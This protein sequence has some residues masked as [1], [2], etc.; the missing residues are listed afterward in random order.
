[1]ELTNPSHPLYPFVWVDPERVSGQPCFR[2]TRLP[3]KTLFDNLSHG[4]TVDEFIATFQ[5]VSREMVLGVLGAIADQLDLQ[6]LLGVTN[7]QGTNGHGNGDSGAA[8]LNRFAGRVAWPEDAMDY[9]RRSRDEW[10]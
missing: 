9:Q 10:S 7:G 1:M 2:G 4:S 8:D 3:V 6:R 5:G